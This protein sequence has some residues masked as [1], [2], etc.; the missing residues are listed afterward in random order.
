KGHLAFAEQAFRRL[1]EATPGARM[2]RPLIAELQLRQGRPD[3]AVAE[4]APLLEDP[5]TAAPGLRR[6]AGELQLAAGRPDIA[7]PLLQD[8]MAAM[9]GEPRTMA[10]IAEAWRRL[11]ASEDAR[12]SLDAALAYAPDNDG[13]WR[14][15]LAF[16][17]VDGD[18]ETLV[19]R[20]RAGCPDSIDA[21]EA[22]MVVHAQRG[23]PAEAEAAAHA[24]LA[25]APGH[26]RAEMRV[27]DALMA[28]EP[29]EAVKRIEGLLAG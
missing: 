22:E 14:T 1:L 28:R 3:D 27:I 10:A 5:A 25:R 12:R 9:P 19:A 21:L 6:F 4:I 18:A 11:G 2:V 26:A 23:R 17:P 8:A 29:A 20:W 24:L 13:L 15:R 7:L 16:E